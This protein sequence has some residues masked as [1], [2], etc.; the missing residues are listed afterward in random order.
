MIQNKNILLCFISMKLMACMSTIWSSVLYL[1]CLF[2]SFFMQNWILRYTH[3]CIQ[4]FFWHT[5]FLKLS[6]GQFSDTQNPPVVVAEECPKI[7][8]IQCAWGR[9][10]VSLEKI[11]VCKYCR[12]YF[13]YFLLE[14]CI[15]KTLHKLL[16]ARFFGHP[17]HSNSTK[18]H[19]DAALTFANISFNMF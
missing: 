16:R 13:T 1:V 18:I 5:V 17:Y 15:E 6:I 4:M 19:L 9:I 10:F 8:D 7:F 12:L 3:C 2:F 14:I 11:F